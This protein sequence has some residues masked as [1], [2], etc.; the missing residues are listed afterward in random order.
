MPQNTIEETEARILLAQKGLG[1]GLVAE[2]VAEGWL[3][4]PHSTNTDPNSWF[5]SHDGQI[6]NAAHMARRVFSRYT[7]RHAAPSTH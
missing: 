3:F 4:Y 7:E 6:T 5:V 1:G 2:N